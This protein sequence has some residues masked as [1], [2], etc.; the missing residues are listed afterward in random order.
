MG[1]GSGSPRTISTAHKPAA[2]AL[3]L[4]GEKPTHTILRTSMDPTLSDTLPS[5]ELPS[6]HAVTADLRRVR[7][8]CFTP[9]AMKSQDTC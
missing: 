1:K 7:P 8:P 5:P 4:S 9:E 3:A 6:Q 2:E